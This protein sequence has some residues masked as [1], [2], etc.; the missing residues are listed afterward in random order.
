MRGRDD[1]PLRVVLS[2][3][4]DLNIFNT[5]IAELSL[6]D[7]RAVDVHVTRVSV[8][9][10]IDVRRGR[11]S[12]D[13][14]FIEVESVGPVEFNDSEVAGD[15]HFHQCVFRDEVRFDRARLAG[16]L[17]LVHSTFH[18]DASFEGGNYHG[19]LQ[20][21]NV[22]AK[23]DFFF[24]RV[25]VHG[26]VVLTDMT[27]RGDLLQEQG[28]YHGDVVIRKVSVEGRAMFDG[29]TSH[30]NRTFRD[31]KFEGP[32]SFRQGMYTGS[33][34]FE[35]VTFADAVTFEEA[36]FHSKVVFRNVEFAGPVN[37]RGARFHDE[38][39]FEHVTFGAVDFHVQVRWLTLKSV[40]FANQ[41]SMVLD[42]AEAWIEDAKFAA[43]LTLD[44][45]TSCRVPSLTG[46]DATNLV[47]AQVDLSACPL[48]NVYNLDRIKV[49][50]AAFP[51]C[52]T[53][54]SFGWRWPF[55]IRRPARRVIPEEAVVR[56]KTDRPRYSGDWRPLAAE[57][58]AGAQR[59]SA[60]DVAR[61]YRQLRKAREEAKDEPGAADFYY[62]EME[63]RRRAAPSWRAERFV[64][65]LY[66]L[67][68]GY[69]LR[70]SRAVACL[71]ALVFVCATLMG[72]IGFA[73]PHTWTASLVY[74]ADSATKLI[75]FSTSEK[76]TGWGVT[77]QIL[78][79]LAGPVLLGLAVLSIRGR[80]KR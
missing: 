57:L 53:G 77:L 31:L 26:D 72:K 40:S 28:L 64:L 66:W 20:I 68:S 38:L 80:T 22:E 5:A 65:W 58:W 15:F 42:Y 39:R 63:M 52:P 67:T 33:I 32:V 14:H 24:G 16:D 50:S 41:A 76:L 7:G 25:T 4:T 37:F 11:L 60:S 8:T 30:G 2:K 10:R 54:W 3:V 35:H 78:V 23:S 18:G 73:D 49:E 6:Y 34:I 21:R 62:G 56:M 9:E 55:A 45:M 79:R 74:I 43:P 27:F 19:D 47:L 44:S 12:G 36:V 29:V 46:T 1:I 75:G 69:G 51:M 71:V 59:V 48:T 61:V 17:H 13:T 70:A